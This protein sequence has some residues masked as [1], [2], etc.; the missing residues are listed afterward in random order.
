M[1]WLGTLTLAAGTAVL[2]LSSLT[3]GLAP[4]VGVRGRWSFA[5]G[6]VVRGLSAAAERDLPPAATGVVYWQGTPLRGGASVTG[7]VGEQTIIAGIDLS[8]SRADSLGGRNQFPGGGAVTLSASTSGALDEDGTRWFAGDAFYVRPFGNDRND[9]P[10]R[11]IPQGSFGGISGPLLL[12]TRALTWTPTVT[13]LRETSTATLAVQQGGILSRTALSSSAWT[14]A[15]GLSVDMPIGG[16]ITLSPEVGAV[17]GT[18]S[19]TLAQTTG[20]VLGRRGRVVNCT[21]TGG[22]ADAV[23]GWWGGVMVSV[24]YQHSRPIRVRTAAHAATESR[25]YHT[26]TSDL[27]E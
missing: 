14:V 19:S 16:A 27:A 23:R 1:G 18:V 22:S 26:P 13:L 2:D 24:R 15:G 9:Q 17:G 10:T 6:N 21:N 5:V 11:L 8:T 7:F 25:D 20:R 4:Q 12:E 3:L